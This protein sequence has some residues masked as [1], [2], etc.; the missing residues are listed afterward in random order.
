MSINEPIKGKATSFDIAYR[1]GV[2][3]SRQYHEPLRDSDL[4][5]LETRNKI[6]AI[7]KD[8]KLQS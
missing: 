5:N 2:Y 6:K 7:A 1:A 8:V 3:P 4:V